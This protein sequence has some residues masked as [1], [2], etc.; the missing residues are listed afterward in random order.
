MLGRWLRRGTVRRFLRDAAGATA[1]EYGILV[2]FIFLALITGIAAF[3]N[4]TGNIYSNM[5]NRV[6]GVLSR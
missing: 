3:G 5:S 4:S 6:T 1:I 2:C